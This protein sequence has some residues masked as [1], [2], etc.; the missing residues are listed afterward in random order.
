MTVEAS[1][2]TVLTAS[3]PRVFRNFAEVSTPR[4]YVTYQQIGGQPLAYLGREV[5]S[6]EN[7]EYQI[8]VWADTAKEAKQLIK[9]IEAGLIQSTAFQATALSGQ[10]GDFDSDIPVHGYRQDFSIWSDR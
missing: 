4:P 2:T 6:K 10:V 9:Q 1:I 3:C 7:G 5:P 8:N